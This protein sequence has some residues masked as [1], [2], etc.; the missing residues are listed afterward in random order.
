M[1]IPPTF[2]TLSNPAADL[3]NRVCSCFSTSEADRSLRRLLG[4]GHLGLREQAAAGA[5]VSQKRDKK[6]GVFNS[7]P[8][9]F[10]RS[11]RHYISIF[12]SVVP[13]PSGFEMLCSLSCFSLADFCLPLCRDHNSKISA[14]KKIP[15]T[16]PL[17]LFLVFITLCHLFF[18]KN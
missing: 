1:P 17:F 2:K 15:S 12:I 4:R 9:S 16:S 14:P 11:P 10:F 13:H 6:I 5:P 3:L 8:A 18:K 7:G